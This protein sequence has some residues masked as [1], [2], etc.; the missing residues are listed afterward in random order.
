MGKKKGG[1][2]YRGAD[3][4]G[5]N[6]DVNKDFGSQF[7]GGRPEDQAN[8]QARYNQLLTQSKSLMS[9]AMGGGGPMVKSGEGQGLDFSALEKPPGKASKKGGSLLTTTNQGSLFTR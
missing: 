7:G 5:T 3:Y 4:S 1:D 2:P 9:G 8:A 6:F